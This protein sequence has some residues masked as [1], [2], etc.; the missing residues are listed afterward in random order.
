MERIKT[1]QLYNVIVASSKKGGIGFKGMLPWKLPADV[2]FFK[3]ITTET[4]QTSACESLV[5]HPNLGLSGKELFNKIKGNIQSSRKNIVVM[6]RSTWDSIPKK[7][8]PLDNRINV[9]LSGSETFY[10][11]NTKEKGK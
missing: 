8:R 11:N 7:Y 10:K 6:G 1:K 4:T 5:T 3:K 9:V 2:Q